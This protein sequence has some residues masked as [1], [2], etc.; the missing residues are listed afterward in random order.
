MGNPNP[1][2]S[3]LTPFSGVDDPR[4]INKPKGAIHLSTRIQNMMNDESFEA[5]ILDPKIGIKAYKGTPAQAIIQV[6]LTKALAGDAKMMEWLAK[7]GY[8][9]KQEIEHTGMI[10]DGQMDPELMK[11]FAEFLKNKTKS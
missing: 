9:T 2:T 10:A 7:Y 11:E 6:A 4:R 8:G 5:N 1:N 3:G